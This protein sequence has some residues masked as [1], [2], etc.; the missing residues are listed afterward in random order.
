MLAAIALSFCTVCLVKMKKERYVWVTA[1]PTAWLVICTLTTGWMKLFDAD[2]RIGFLA[3]ARKFGDAIAQGQVLAPAKSLGE[4]ARVVFN[5][6]I[7]A[8]LT[9]LLMAL[10]VTLV[11]LGTKAAIRA[12]RH[13]DVSTR[14]TPYV[15]A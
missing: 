1:A 2:P 11:A 4:M 9:V 5:D 14:E 13:G 10:V 12:W 15:A 7:D 6:R 8:A 3:H